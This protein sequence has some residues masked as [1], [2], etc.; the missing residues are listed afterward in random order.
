[1]T[2]WVDFA[3]LSVR[4]N[5]L[6]KSTSECLKSYLEAMVRGHTAWNML[7]YKTTLKRTFLG[8]GLHVSTESDSH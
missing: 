6:V 8:W 2:C 3:Y 4:T 1:M 7:S 5:T